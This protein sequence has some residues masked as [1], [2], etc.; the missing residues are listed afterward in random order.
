MP[1]DAPINLNDY[2]RDVADF[3]KPGIMFKDITPL[4]LNSTA[5]EACI[6]EMADKVS[7]LKICLLYTSPSP[8]DRG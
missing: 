6:D 4:L 7:D 1:N 3:P 8:R 5:F 2:I